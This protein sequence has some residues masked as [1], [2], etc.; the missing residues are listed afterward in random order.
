[1]R[2]RKRCGRF[3][4]LCWGEGG[5]FE[6]E[7]LA[8]VGVFR[9]CV[10][11]VLDRDAVRGKAGRERSPIWPRTVPSMIDNSTVQRFARLAKK[12]PLHQRLK[13]ETRWVLGRGS[14]GKIL[15]SKRAK[16]VKAET[17]HVMSRMMLA[18]LCRGSQNS[19]LEGTVRSGN[20]SIRMCPVPGCRYRVCPEEAI[21]GGILRFP[22]R[23]YKSTAYGCDGLRKGIR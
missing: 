2:W 6:R 18:A 11:L 4:A 15:L 1:M 16:P 19:R 17:K 21:I 5:R 13:G 14:R 8:L 22:P 12:N 20:W 7:L 23:R 10:E 3:A 9:V